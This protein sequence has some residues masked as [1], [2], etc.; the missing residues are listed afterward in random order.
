MIYDVIIGKILEIYCGNSAKCLNLLH[1]LGRRNIT[2]DFFS[3]FQNNQ[4]CLS[5]MIYGKQLADPYIM[6][7]VV[8]AIGE[9]Y[10]KR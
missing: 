5:F 4:M 1:D 3:L 6:Q 2:N 7:E 9:P 8:S 10:L